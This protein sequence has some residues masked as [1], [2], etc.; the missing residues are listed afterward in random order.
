MNESQFWACFVSVCVFVCVCVCVAVWLA[1]WLAGS[2]SVCVCVCVFS[3]LF[4]FNSIIMAFMVDRTLN[5]SRIP[6]E[7]RTYQVIALYHLERLRG[8]GGGG[9]KPKHVVCTCCTL[10][11]QQPQSAFL[12]TLLT[13]C[14]LEPAHRVPQEQLAALMAVSIVCQPGWSCQLLVP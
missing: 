12:C 10:T 7:I 2:L 5:H 8:G 3:L 1:V 13:A 4:R 14:I 6:L 11:V 9:G